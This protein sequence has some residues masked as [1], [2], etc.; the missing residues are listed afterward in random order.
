MQTVLINDTDFES[1]YRLSVSIDRTNGWVLKSHLDTEFLT[2]GGIIGKRYT[3]TQINE[4]YLESKKK[5]N[6]NSI[7]NRSPSPAYHILI[8]LL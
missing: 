1:S 4:L 5:E 3:T 6:V 2:V 7:D 8:V